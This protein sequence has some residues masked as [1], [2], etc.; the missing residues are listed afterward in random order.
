MVEYGCLNSLCHSNNGFLKKAKTAKHLAK[1]YTTDKH[2]KKH[3]GNHTTTNISYMFWV[4]YHDRI[5]STVFNS[6]AVSVCI[7]SITPTLSN[8]INTIDETTQNNINS[9][10]TPYN[11]KHKQ[12]LQ[13]VFELFMVFVYGVYGFRSVCYGCG[14][15]YCE[16]LGT[17]N[18]IIQYNS[19][20]ITHSLCLW[21]YGFPC[22]CVFYVV[23]L[24]CL[25][26]V[27]LCYMFCSCGLPLEKAFCEMTQRVQK[28]CALL[29]LAFTYGILSWSDTRGSC[30][31]FVLFVLFVCCVSCCV[32]LFLFYTALYCPLQPSTAL[33][34]P[35]LPSP[36]IHF[37]DLHHYGTHVV[38][39][40]IEFAAPVESNRW[41]IGFGG[42][43]GY[44]M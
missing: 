43:G 14:A 19:N 30:F 21:L 34:C 36:S 13:C 12:C 29:F 8:T 18:E 44:H 28:P 5:M 7:K 15:N 37:Q 11:Y 3:K 2:N 35:L 41:V 23:F 9:E 17:T 4:I 42:G 27:W 20:I 22:V 16:V 26:L 6:F 32:M 31:C 38:C 39:C 33:Y 1:P 24:C 40:N 10:G 25:W